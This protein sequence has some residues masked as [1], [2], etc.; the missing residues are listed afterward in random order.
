MPDV[1]LLPGER[2]LQRK[3]A[4][5]L[6]TLA[7]YGLRPQFRAVMDRIGFRSQRRWGEIVAN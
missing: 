2:E 1:T 7:D 3:K 4:N 5:A 6:E